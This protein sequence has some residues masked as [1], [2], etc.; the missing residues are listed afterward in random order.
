MGIPNW[1]AQTA[2]DNDWVEQQSSAPQGGH[3]IWVR[4]LGDDWNGWEKQVLQFWSSTHTCTTSLTHP[5]GPGNPFNNQ[6]HRDNLDWEQLA[7]VFEDPRCHTG[8]GRYW[9][10]W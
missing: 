9:K 10:K 8:Q 3:Q 5:N 6:L 4:W 7:W 1:V 2:Y